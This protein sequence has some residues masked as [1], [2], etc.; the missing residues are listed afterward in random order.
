MADVLQPLEI[1]DSEVS[2]IAGILAYLGRVYS[3]NL[4]F[5]TNQTG[6]QLHAETPP[7]ADIQYIRITIY[8]ATNQR[9]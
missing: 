7:K 2:L 8:L 1:A 5:G 3:A 9:L 6:Y 4:L